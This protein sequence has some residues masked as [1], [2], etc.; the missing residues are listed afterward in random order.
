M[1]AIISYIVIFGL[2][3]TL[4][5]VYLFR[6]DK[7]YLLPMSEQTF[8]Q[9]IMTILVMKEKNKTE[10]IVLRLTPL[11]KPLQISELLLE[12]TDEH[13]ERKIVDLKPIAEMTAGVINLLPSEKAEFSIPFQPFKELLSELSFPYERF[14]M[15]AGTPEGKKFKSH[16]LGLN[17][18]WG[19]LKL[20]SGKYN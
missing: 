6:K 20:D 16:E 19:L 4:T 12:L 10:E 13:H 11:K 7:K 8:P 15:T 1:E 2:G 14:R 17:P 9:L 3:I 18:R 5:A